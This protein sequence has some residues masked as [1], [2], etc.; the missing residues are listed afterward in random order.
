[1]ALDP[2]KPVSEHLALGFLTAC[3]A[4]RRVTRGV[5]E[6]TAFLMDG[7]LV[8]QAAEGESILRLPWFHRGLFVGRQ[9][10]DISEMPRH[11]RSAAVAHYRAALAG[12]P[13]GFA[14]V[15]YGHAYS[16]D[17]VP[18][19][20]D[21]G[22]ITAVLGIATPAREFP[23]AATA[24]ERTAERLERSAA[25][26]EQRA[27]RHR[28]AGRR[29]EEAAQRERARRSWGAAKRARVHA[30]RLRAGSADA[31]APSVT[32]READVLVL[33]S[34]GLTS[35]EIAEQ[36]V[37]SPSTVRTHLKNIY[38]KLG[39]ATR[40]PPSPPPCGTA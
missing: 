9:L 24:Y 17:A 29:A 36:L 39:V 4:Q 34:H 19:I 7:E 3:A 30:R 1:M 16:V 15:S 38:L 8:V 6:S 32:P 2:N 25:T 40:R 28:A 5:P 20:C 23:A 14:F 37:V 22:R 33:A 18:V 10:A 12:E 35:G 13:G 27:E 31:D 21:D 11:V 26:A